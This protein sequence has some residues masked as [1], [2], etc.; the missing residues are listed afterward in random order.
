MMSVD[1]AQKIPR[2][3]IGIGLHRNVP[4]ETCTSYSFRTHDTICLETNL[5]MSIEIIYSFDAH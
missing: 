2:S 4:K 5:I 1:N 3:L